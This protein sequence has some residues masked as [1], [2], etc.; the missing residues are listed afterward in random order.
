MGSCFDQT[1]G[2]SHPLKGGHNFYTSMVF[3]L[4]YRSDETFTNFSRLA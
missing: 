3:N 4:I 2:S 1:K